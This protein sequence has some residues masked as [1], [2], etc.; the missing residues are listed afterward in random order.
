MK[1][2]D[3]TPMRRAQALTLASAQRE[4]WRK[5]HAMTTTQLVRELRKHEFHMSDY[6]RSYAATIC[7]VFPC[8][9][10]A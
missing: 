8:G 7:A 2:A 9:T 6:C 4:L 1:L 5:H 3:G 10:S